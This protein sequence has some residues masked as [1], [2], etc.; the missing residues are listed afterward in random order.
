MDVGP[1]G[2]PSFALLTTGG[3]D[4][5]LLPKLVDAINRA[6]KI[7]ITVAFIRSSGL[8]LLFKALSDAVERGIATRLL[9]SDY[10]DVTDPQALRRLMLLKEQG[11][12]IRIYQCDGQQ[13]FHMKSYI[14][15]H[16]EKDDFVEGCAYVGSSNISK[17]ALTTGNEWNLRLQ[18]SGYLDDLY[19]QQFAHIR[20]QFHEI[21]SHE[22]VQPLSHEWIDSYLKR[23]RKMQLVAVDA[24]EFI[25]APPTPT[26]IQTEAL[27][28]L[29]QTRNNGYQRGLVVLATGLGKTWLAAFDTQQ[30]RAEK[31]LFVAHRKEILIQAQQT[32]VRIRPDARTG[33]YNGEE[34]NKEADMLF[35]S[36]KTLGQMEHLQQFSKDHFDYIVVDEF[37]HAYAKTYRD[38]LKH[39][40]PKFLLGLTATPE[41]TDQADVL[42]LCDNNLV[43]ERD[44][45]HGINARLLA[46]FRYFGI[47]DRYVNYKEI[48]WRNGKLDSGALEN[49]FATHRRA[50]HI[51][52]H[53]QEKKQKRTL[54]FCI[55]TRHADFMASVFVKAG[56]RAA[57]V[58][59][60][61]ELRRHEA[62]NQ[63][64]AGELDV[65]FSVDLFNEGTDLPAI[66]TVLMLRPT[67]SKILFLQQLG[68]GLR[69]HQGKQHLVVI[70]F[71][72]NHKSFLIKPVVLQ[73]CHSVREVAEQISQQRITLPDGCFANYDPE[74]I[75]FLERMARA[76]NASI[77]DEYQSLKSLL[78]YRPTATEFY[79]YLAETGTNFNRV[80]SQHGSWFK[81]LDHLE[82]LNTSESEVANT[83]HQ[84]LLDG[85]EKTK[86]DKC[87]K[88]ILLDAFLE[89]DGFISAPTTEAL[90]AKSWHLLKRRPTLYKSELPDRQQAMS[91]EDNGWHSYWKRNPIKA[92]AGRKDTFFE[93]KEERFTFKT[94][95][96]PKHRDI[97]HQLVQELVALR[98]E[99]YCVRKELRQR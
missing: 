46:P 68:R 2:P 27:Q 36:V 98:L 37:H 40:E 29:Q 44:L 97:L 42:S 90:A 99:Q 19:V 77:V 71:I 13:S 30:C 78:G 79:H 87:F 70:D 14:F 72:G 80:R 82:E 83:H 16:T 75:D 43:F 95:V 61:S 66:D 26:E 38:L 92:F 23:R 24:E 54:G 69:L 60:G 20:L 1:I 22:L 41:R 55:T 94:D 48:P 18:C 11:A 17:A 96:K 9:T 12:D 5:P 56:F 33:F 15:I 8:E 59:S 74:V 67:E 58:H 57:A 21:F 85:I 73:N 64:E 39:F 45:I 7:E 47:N 91:A 65:L 51:L 6:R 49:A 4:D 93:V 53:W 89:L 88:M 62:L 86:M 35:A 81:L 31:V 52:E 50:Q 28:A 32:F 34:R 10:L 63:L 3:L 84:F 76:Q 25:E